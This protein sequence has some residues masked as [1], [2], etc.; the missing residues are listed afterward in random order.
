VTVRV[1]TSQV[2][3]TPSTRL[4]AHIYYAIMADARER[5][6][7][8]DGATANR[9]TVP[10]GR[11]FAL[12]QRMNPDAHLVWV[13]DM[14]GRPRA[15]T[16]KQA[17]VL[18]AALE[19]AHGAK[20]MTM[21]DMAKALQLAPS[22]VSRALTKLQA[23]GLIAYMVGRG[24]FAGLVIFRRA[25]DDGMDRFRKAAQARVRRWKEAASER[26]SRLWVNVAPYIMEERGR[27]Y[28]GH[29]YLSTSKGA[30]LTAQRPWTPE[31]L[32]EAG[33]I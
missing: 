14:E 28:R 6:P 21:R 17:M 31:E 3:P 30:T 24:R 8:Q 11:G 4:P 19:M 9:A 20:G 18:A 25:K 26:V 29:Y 12:W 32:R 1:E 13:D 5:D 7:I 16:P 2:T 33:I 23:W 10:M 27:G 15:L 22:T